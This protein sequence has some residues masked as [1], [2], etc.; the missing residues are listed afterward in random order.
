MMRLQQRTSI[1]YIAVALSLIILQNGYSNP[2]DVEDLPRYGSLTKNG[3][4]WTF[5]QEVPVGQFITGDYY[6]VG[7]VTIVAIDPSPT[8]ENGRHGSALNLPGNGRDVSPFDDRT[9]SNRYREHLRSYP[10]IDMVPGDVLLS[11]VS[12]ES[13]GDFQA[14]LREGYETPSSY[15]RSVSVLHVLEEP[16]SADA[17]RP[18]YVGGPKLWYYA[19]DLRRNL[20]PALEKV[21]NVYDINTLA[22]HFSR[23]WL[24]ITY[25]GFDAAVEYQAVYGREV[26]RA[27]G[28]ASLALMLD[29]S[30][31][32]KEDLLIGLVQYAIDLWHIAH[33]GHTGW[34]AHGGHGSGR[35]WPLIFTGILLEDPEMVEPSSTFPELRFGEDMHTAYDDCWTGANVV[36]TGHQ[37]LWDGEPVSSQPH[38]GPYEHLH[39]SEWYEAFDGHDRFDIGESYRRCCTSVAWVGQALAAR[40]MRAEDLWG[41]VAFFDYVDRWMT[42]DDTE[43]VQILDQVIQ[44]L[45]GRTYSAG[46]QRQG[47]AWDPFVNNM[48]A[49]YRDNLP[50]SVINENVYIADEL[51]LEQN[52]PNP[53]NPITTI[54]YTL[55]DGGHTI[56]IVYDILGREV[57][58]LVNGFKASGSYIVQ[59]DG[60]DSRG[61]PVGSGTYFYRLQTENEFS[62]IKRM[63]LLR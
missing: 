50:T 47:Q 43:H 18:G 38:W 42:E 26:G 35:K 30:S 29:Y 53:F 10:P 5:S 56:L 62:A 60:R 12:I 57:T 37:G 44:P 32:E 3:V 22:S 51:I 23:P 14:W 28:M 20:L 48:W 31:D 54:G 39:P 16:V 45:V 15:V 41:H 46:W 21:E 19:N 34:P 52:Y 1:L 40:I 58:E 61:Q 6:I 55:P 33:A 25:F 8:E 59:W 13:G 49:A 4:T 63:V 24:D 27:V 11:S 7:P 2:P 17:F 36:Y 9:S